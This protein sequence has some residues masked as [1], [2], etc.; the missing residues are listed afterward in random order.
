MELDEYKER[1]ARREYIAEGAEAHL[2]MTDAAREAQRITAEINGSYHSAEELRTL[3]S[4]LTGE[5]VD[6]TFGLKI[7]LS[8]RDA[9]RTE[10]TRAKHCGGGSDVVWE[11][12]RC[13]FL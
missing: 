4:R 11:Q 6:E 9:S 2:L 3:F 13:A 10:R 7:S 12:L 5:R 8:G 1:T